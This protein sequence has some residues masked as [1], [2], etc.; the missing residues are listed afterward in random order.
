MWELAPQSTS[1]MPAPDRNRFKPTKNM[2]P[3][4]FARI[5]RASREIHSKLGLEVSPPHPLILKPKPR[6]AEQ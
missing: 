5:Q 1:N 3:A 4:R 6:N 2:V